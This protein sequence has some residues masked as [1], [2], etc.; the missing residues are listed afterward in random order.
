[1]HAAR[2]FFCV[3][4][5]GTRNVYSLAQR[6]A[7][8]GETIHLERWKERLAEMEGFVAEEGNE[9]V[10][11]MT[12]DNTGYITLAFVLPSAARQGIGAGL[13]NVVETRARL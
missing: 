11:L 9:P 3:I 5:E 10:G 13:L 4:H 7:W 6:L 2:I 1:M 8:A 12:I